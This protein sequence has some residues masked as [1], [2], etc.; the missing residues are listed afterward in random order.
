[1]VITTM[2]NTELVSLSDAVKPDYF[3]KKIRF[4]CIVTGKSI[5]PYHIP[6]K[7]KIICSNKNKRCITND[8]INYNYI[9]DLKPDMRFIGTNETFFTQIISNILNFSCR[10]RF[11]I[12]EV[13]TVEELYVKS[14]L[15]INSDEMHASNR[16]AYF[17]GYNMPCNVEIEAHGY[18]QPEPKQQKVIHVINSF[19]PVKTDVDVFKP[20]KQ[21]IQ[22][23]QIFNPEDMDSVNSI[24]DKLE[25]IYNIYAHN[26]TRIYKRFDLHLAV[27]LAFHSVLSFNL[28]NEYIHKGWADIMIL[29]D[30]RCGKNFVAEGLSKYYKIG[31]IVSGENVSV[32]GL[33]GGVQQISGR[34]ILTWGKIP[35]NDKKLLIIDEAG[36]MN[37]IFIALSRVRSEGIAEIT[38]IRSD[39]N[40]TRTRL[41]FLA[42]PKNRPLSTYSYGIESITDI[43]SNAEDI[44]RFDY[45]LTV[46]NDEVSLEDINIFAVK[47]D[48]PYEKFDN[49]LILWAWSRKPDKIK[50]KPDALTKLID[51]SIKLGNLYSSQIPLIQGENIRIKL[52]KIA[53]MIAVRLF[54]AS[55]DGEK[56]IVTSIHIEAAYVF[57]QM[58]YKKKSSA[59]FYYSKIKKDI[60]TIKDIEILERYI[61]SFQNWESIMEYLIGTNYITAT[62]MSDHINQPKDMVREI[63]STLLKHACIQKKYTFYVKNPGFSEWLRKLLQ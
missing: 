18:T 48:N 9:F 21:M 8:C 23:L 22:D 58:I 61:K 57:L 19:K 27:D 62:D 46:A 26:I 38:K 15:N 13:Y 63:I 16:L 30:T 20:S 17:I 43:I 24:Y 54:S 60:S 36:N 11:K 49:A 51:Y 50:F 42:N 31:D 28:S 4:R 7:I 55:A 6:K 14:V 41:I 39:T 32:A 10:F 56:I 37:D 52:A 45:V 53:V 29:G 12:L 35:Q 44:S 1:M 25:N 2:E 3:R 5:M 40:Y 33:I 34:W 59:Y 47:Q